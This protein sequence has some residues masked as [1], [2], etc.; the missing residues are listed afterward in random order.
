[1]KSQN[2]LFALIPLAIVIIAAVMLIRSFEARLG[3]DHRL[4][5]QHDARCEEAAR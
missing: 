3:C 2:D 1:M 5:G 4:D